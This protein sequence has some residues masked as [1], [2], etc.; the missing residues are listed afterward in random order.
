[1][2]I[3]AAF[4]PGDVGNLRVLIEVFLNMGRL[5]RESVVFGGRS[6]CGENNLIQRLV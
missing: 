6:W 4:V 3:Y 1:M 2:T 5:M